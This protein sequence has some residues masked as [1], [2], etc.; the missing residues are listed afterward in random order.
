MQS[1]LGLALRLGFYCFLIVAGLPLFAFALSLGGYLVTAA[2]ATFCAGLVA[3]FVSLRVFDRMPLQAAGL[4]WKTGSGKNL[5]L[6]LAAGAGAALLVTLVPVLAG[7]AQLVPDAAYPASAPG[8][9]FVSVVLLFG[10]V[11]EELI[12]RGYGFQI[13]ASGAGRILA[14]AISSFLFGMVHAQNLNVSALAVV[15]TTGFGVVLGL[16]M[17][18]S[19]DL[20]LPIGLHFAW[21]LM[22]PL[23]GVNLSGFRIGLTG[24]TL[25]WNAPD[26]WSGGAYGPEGS[27]LTCCVLVLLVWFLAKAPV[28]T[29]DAPLLHRLDEEG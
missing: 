28:V 11:G 18:R 20:W 25:R 26:L 29:A 1:R 2:G 5:G 14:V 17:I 10:A 15:N 19:G 16:G 24:Y 12:F 9:L 13:L 21:N 4:Y 3:N 27:V 7:A 23:A 6:G 22:L 8:F